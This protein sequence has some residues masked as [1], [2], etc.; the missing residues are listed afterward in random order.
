MILFYFNPYLNSQV[1]ILNILN[2][3]FL[4]TIILFNSNKIVHKILISW[5]I[6]KLTVKVKFKKLMI[7]IFVSNNFFYKY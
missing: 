5:S 4:S 6:K 7:I 3:F 1:L 2:N